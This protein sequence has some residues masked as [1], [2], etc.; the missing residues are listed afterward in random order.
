M[1]S[2][3]LAVVSAGQA[4][5]FDEGIEYRVVPKPERLEPGDGVEV[6]EL[7]W[8]GCPHCYRL[9]PAIKAWLETKP[10]GVRFRRLPAAASSRWIPHAK[11]FFAAEQ[12]GELDTL[13]EP[14]FKAL[15]EERRALYT[16]EQLIAFAAELGIDEEAFREAYASFP[17]DMQVRRSADLARGYQLTGVPAI[18]VNGKYITGVNDAGGTDK[19]FELI[20]FLVA[21]EQGGGASAEATD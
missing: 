16:D 10:E 12:L 18:V 20:D 19:L 17:V 14:L 7:F 13:H 11:A 8:Y 1:L 5:G 2:V 3:C 21:K 9:E 4:A 15:H 6:L